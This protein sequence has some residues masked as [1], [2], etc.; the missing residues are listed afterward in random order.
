MLAMTA[1]GTPAKHKG[2]HM[3]SMGRN[4]AIVVMVL[5]MALAPMA[6]TKKNQAS[7]TNAPESGQS[8]A[9]PNGTKYQVAFVPKLQ[10]IPYFEAMNAGGQEAAAKLG[11]VNWLYQGST[12]ADAA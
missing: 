3:R 8:S 7:P 6:C 11:N 12:S 4:W 9:A 2:V 1:A 10:G 5:A